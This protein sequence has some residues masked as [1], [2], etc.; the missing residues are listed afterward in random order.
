MPASALDLSPSRRNGCRSLRRRRRL[1][2]ATWSADGRWFATVGEGEIILWE[3]VIDFPFARLRIV[4]LH[5]ATSR[6]EFSPDARLLVT[7]GGD[8]LAYAL[9]LEKLSPH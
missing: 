5:P 6:A 8:S 7:Y 4:D 2:L 1:S 9:D 3:W